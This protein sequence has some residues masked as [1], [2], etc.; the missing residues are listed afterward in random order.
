MFPSSLTQ[1]G[2]GRML[3]ASHS[4]IPL[5]PYHITFPLPVAVLPTVARGRPQ[6]WRHSDSGTPS[7]AS[8]NQCPKVLS[9]SVPNYPYQPSRPAN[10]VCPHKAQVSPHTFKTQVNWDTSLHCCAQDMVA[11]QQAF[12][13][14]FNTIDNMSR[15]YTI[16]TDPSVPPCMEEG[17]HR[18]PRADWANPQW[19]GQQRCHSSCLPSY[20]VGI[21]PNIPPQA[22]STLCICLNPK[23]LNKAIVWEIT[24]PYFW[25][26]FPS[27]KQCYLLQ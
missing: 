8:S 17:T 25:W 14:S 10:P 26:D 12:P 27:T 7:A 23:E 18:V 22:C 5:Y 3:N 6:R 4:G 1:A 11:L 24:S 21:I 15:M 16:R 20:W 19:H 9:C 13:G 2:W